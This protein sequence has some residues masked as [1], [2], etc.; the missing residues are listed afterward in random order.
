MDQ[1]NLDGVQTFGRGGP[2]ICAAI[3]AG[4]LAVNHLSIERDGAFRF[5]ILFL[6]PM[7]TLLGLGGLVDP[8]IF[9]S[10]GPRGQVL[11][12]AVKVVG[13]CLAMAGIAVSVALIFL[14]YELH[15]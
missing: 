7:F 10:I 12:T 11:P 5:G 8:R 2:A 13:A 9:W 3:G 15:I 6:A 14:V 4:L 1:K